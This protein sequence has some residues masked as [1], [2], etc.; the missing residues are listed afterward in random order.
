M[1]KVY[2]DIETNGLDDADTIWIFGGK[3][4]ETGEV[5]RF[6]P[7]R[8]EKE[9]KAAI[10]W[11][12]GVDHWIGHN[13]ISYDVP[14]TN[15]LLHP[16]LIDMARVTDTLIESRTI[17]YDIAT[18][19]GARGPH[20]L[21]AWGLRLGQHKGDYNN[22]KEYTDEM[23]PYW[24]GDLDTT[25]ALYKFLSK[26][27]D[28]P[29]WKKALEVE[30]QV[31]IELTRQKFYGFYF[32]KEDAEETL[33][34][35]EEELEA[36]TSSIQED[37]PPTL[38]H[39]K[40]IQYRLKKDGDEMA[41]VAK[42]KEEADMT[43]VQGDQLLCYR[44]EAFN[45]GSPKQRVEKLWEAGWNPIE[46]TKTHQKFA[47]LKVGMP[48]GKSVDAMDQEF[49]D[50]KRKH[51]DFYGWTVSEDNLA[52]LPES[53]PDGAR[54]LAQW[55][56]LEGRR[57]SLTE[58]IGQV[59]DDHRIHGTTQHIGAWTG[60]GAHKDPNTA[61]IAS[62]WYEDTPVRTAVDAVKAKYDTKLRSYWCVPDGSWMVGVDADGIQLR[63]LA[64]YLWRYFE[65]PEYA[66]A[67][68]EGKKEDETDIHNMNRKALGLDWLI[69]DDAKTFIYAWVL[70]AGDPKVASILRSTIP[71]AVQAKKRFES[72]IPGL[73][74]FKS[75]MLPAI[76]DKGWFT[77]YD[78]R[79]VMVP[80]LHKTLAGILQNGESVVMKHA[81]VKW[82]S[83]LRGDGINYKP[84]SWVH[85]EWQTEVI[86]SKEEALHVKQVQE[87]SIAWAGKEL[88]FLI[89]TPGSGSIGSNWAETH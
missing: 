3:N 59:R 47:R 38:E 22:W 30:H 73:T 7:F 25:E 63:I 14:T 89:D 87:N 13:F 41:T 74:P 71:V 27:R 36:L 1:L 76:A 6:E 67:I 69:R 44:Y 16:R 56:T 66:K 4:V 8:G 84:L 60:R 85:D 29:Q 72:S 32:N 64:D 58:W 12:K 53:A 46:K 42:A 19:V 9:T 28:D 2:A 26:Y 81:K 21:K 54:A 5:Y 61:N 15:R 33:Q 37:Y 49:Y 78:G 48:Y 43:T 23:V 40:T 20:S 70:N 31:Q 45:P 35:I 86:G 11:A 65:K 52:T 24:E 10:E 51:L 83:D 79:K 82:H 34:E 50:A 55:L 77:G 39:Y 88:G 57:S 62:V 68:M 75:R 17:C 18:P 80:N